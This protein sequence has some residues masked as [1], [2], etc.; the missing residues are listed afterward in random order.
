MTSLAACTEEPLPDDWLQMRTLMTT[1]LLGGSVQNSHLMMAVELLHDV[2]VLLFG[3]PSINAL[4]TAAPS[5]PFFTKVTV[6]LQT[7]VSQRTWKRSTMHRVVNVLRRVLSLTKAS[8]TTIRSMRLLPSDSGK[9]PILT[10]EHAKRTPDDPVRQRLESWIRV[11]Q[12]HTKN[13]SNLSLRNVM[14]FF[15]H[16]LLPSMELN[17]EMWPDDAERIAVEFCERDGGVRQICN[18]NKKLRWLQFFLTRV[19]HSEFVLPPE[20]THTL[21]LEHKLEAK[22]ALPNEDD[23]TDHHRIA[24]QELEA[25]HGVAVKDMLNEL[26]FLTLLTTGMRIG[27]FVNLKSANVAELKQGKWQAKLEGKTIEKG[28][29]VFTFKIHARVRELTVEWLN[30]RRGFNPSEFLFP[31]RE[32]GHMHT[33]TFR[34]RFSQM[35][36]VAGLSGT[37]YHPHALRHCYS[38]ILLELGNSA[39]VVSKLINHASVATTQKF[40]LKESAAEVGERAIIPWMQ[41][42]QITK[43]KKRAN[44]V[45]DFLASVTVPARTQE[46]RSKQITKARTVFDTLESFNNS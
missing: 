17:L 36:K 44:P 30:K 23:G 26:F 11:L 37:Q 1:E 28:R 46:K 8:P 20:L 25:L 21:R 5:A 24:K 19:L 31:G 15:L 6:S 9:H 32:G 45:P 39:D 14:A 33:H 43:S 38:H 22:A 35:C 18:K 42:N 10:G 29:K 34:R 40:Y 12:Q 2:L 7:A 13:E 3:T 27:G 16:Q 41:D 4:C